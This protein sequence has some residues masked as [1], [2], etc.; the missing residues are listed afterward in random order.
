M[1]LEH[2]L[3]KL[4]FRTD[5]HEDEL[6]DLRDISK[7]LKESLQGIERNM[8]QIKWITAGAVGVMLAQS[9]GVSSLLKAIFL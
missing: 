5:I 2:R 4:E 1:E 9:M 8:L 3:I 7:L 6:K